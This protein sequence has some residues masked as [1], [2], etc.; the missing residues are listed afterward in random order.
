MTT[1]KKEQESKVSKECAKDLIKKMFYVSLV[2]IFLLCICAV[3]AQGIA[4]IYQTVISTVL[5]GGYATVLAM[6]GRKELG[7]S[8]LRV[9]ICGLLGAVL[10]LSICLYAFLD[11]I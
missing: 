8:W 3:F 2:A 7:R 1:E 6:I 11:V 5:L 9:V 4:P 10:G